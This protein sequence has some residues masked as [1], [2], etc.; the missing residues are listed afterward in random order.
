MESHCCSRLQRESFIEHL[1]GILPI[2]LYCLPI[3][4]F[5]ASGDKDGYI[6]IWEAETLQHLKTFKKHRKTVSGLAFRVGT[7]T[8]FSASHDRMVMVWDLDVMAFVENL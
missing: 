7:H 4:F 3:M 1:R 6:H 8:L 2:K 5:Q